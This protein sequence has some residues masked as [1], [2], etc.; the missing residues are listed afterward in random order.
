M[1]II[2]KINKGAGLLKK[3]QIICTTIFTDTW[4]IEFTRLPL[5]SSWISCEDSPN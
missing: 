2:A 3:K 5:E 4:K 1:S